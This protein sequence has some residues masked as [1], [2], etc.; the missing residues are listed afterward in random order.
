MGIVGSFFYY[1]L[2]TL[3]VLTAYRFTFGLDDKPIKNNHIDLQHQLEIVPGDLLLPDG[4]LKMTGRSDY[5]ARK[6]NKDHITPGIFHFK[7][8]N[9]IKFK[10]G[11]IHSF[12]NKDHVI[13]I[14]LIDRN[15]LGQFGFYYYKF[16]EKKFLRHK[17]NL[18]PSQYQKLSD[19]FTYF[20]GSFEL[21]T[22]GFKLSIKD[23]ENK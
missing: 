1:T 2:L 5:V 21:D 13:I 15:Y 12:V 4:K 9:N 6:L 22:K 3:A 18:F 23:T 20:K 19:D 17:E 7:V 16:N 8:F 10:R 14:E 11:M